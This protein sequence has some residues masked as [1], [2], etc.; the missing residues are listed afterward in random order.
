M[1]N[2]GSSTPGIESTGRRG[3]YLAD[4]ARAG[5]GRMSE[6]AHHA[7]DRLSEAASQAAERLGAHSEELWALQGRAAD[8]TRSYIREHPLATIGIAIA[9]GVLISRFTSRR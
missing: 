4:Q 9:I 2:T 3:E 6:T 7:M 8:T 5:L 1:Q